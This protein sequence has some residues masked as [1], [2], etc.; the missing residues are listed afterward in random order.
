M[1]L[2]LQAFF[3]IGLVCLFIRMVLISIQTY[4]VERRDTL[5]FDLMR[6]AEEG[7][8]VVWA[9]VLLWGGR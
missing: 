4:P 6:V 3:W 7:F 8:W 2:F 9:G 5:G 1:K